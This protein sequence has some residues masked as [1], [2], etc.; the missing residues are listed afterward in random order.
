MGFCCCCWFWFLP[1]DSWS[2]H[3]INTKAFFVSSQL[4]QLQLITNTF[5]RGELAKTLIMLVHQHWSVLKWVYY[6]L[7]GKNRR[8][9]KIL[10]KYENIKS[11]SGDNI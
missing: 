6:V 3:E 1:L 9:K 4:W 5:P 8:K 11:C 10:T 7:V 2:V